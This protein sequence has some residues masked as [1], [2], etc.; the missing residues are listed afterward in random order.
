MDLTAV[1]EGRSC[2]AREPSAPAGDH[3]GLQGRFSEVDYT[4]SY[5]R[6]L[7]KAGVSGGAIVY[8]FP[9]R[10]AKPSQHDRALRRRVVNWLPLTPSATLY[11]DVDETSEAGVPVST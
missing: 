10:G 7:G 9:D 8:T 3:S 1:N 6:T 5:A 4:F 11:V 2:S